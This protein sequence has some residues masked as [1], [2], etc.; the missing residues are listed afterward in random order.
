MMPAHGRLVFVTFLFFALLLFGWLA[1]EK[2]NND[3]FSLNA[4]VVVV[5]EEFFVFDFVFC[6][7]SLESERKR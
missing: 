1:R 2:L 6:G 5:D 7:E 3:L 4:T